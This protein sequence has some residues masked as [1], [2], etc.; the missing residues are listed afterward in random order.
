MVRPVDQLRHGPG[1][2]PLLVE[3]Q[4]PGH[5]TG[6]PQHHSVGVGQQRDRRRVVHQR[7]HEGHLVATQ[8]PTSTVGQVP[9]RQQH[10]GAEAPTPHLHQP[11]SVDRVADAELQQRPDRLVLDAVQREGRELQIV[12]VD[13]L[14][15]VQPHRVSHGYAEQVLRSPVAPGHPTTL[16]HDQGG[17]GQRIGHG[18]TE[19]L[20]CI[21]ERRSADGASL[22][23]HRCPIGSAGRCVEVCVGAATRHRRRQISGP[24]SLRRAPAPGPS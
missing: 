15:R 24:S 19:I 5:R 16:V 22:I 14:E 11:P 7:A 10:P 18:V 8:F 4:L 2:D 23:G 20:A 17:V 1:L 9:D 12:R 6:A 3:T 21:G 13:E